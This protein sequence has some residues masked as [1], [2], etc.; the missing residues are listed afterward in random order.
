MD[1][2]NRIGG[3]WS[4]TS[5][6]IEELD[7]STGRP[8][9]AAPASGSAEIDVAVRAAAGAARGWA[10]MPA[11]SRGEILF[12]AAEILGERAAEIAAGIA[13]EIG[14]PIREARGEVARGVAI[15]RYFAGEG[16]RAGGQVIPPDGSGL[17]LTLREPLG[18]VGLITPWNFPLA[19][20]LWKAAPALVV[21]N[22]VVLKP[23]E[24]AAGT[25]TAVVRCL[26]EAGVPA[27]VVGLVC[28]DGRAGSALVAHER[29]GAI[30][31]TGSIPV[32]REIA[33]AAATR[34]VRTQL[35]LGG[36][37]A[38]I[39]LADAD[40]AG[41]A[42]AV[43]NGAF[44]FAGQKCTATGLVL[45]ERAIADDFADRLEAARAATVV[46]AAEDERS[47]CGPLVRADARDRA[48]RSGARGLAGAGYFVE[49]TIRSDVDP[50]SAVCREELFC[51][52]LP[53]VAI[54][55]LDAALEI[56][57]ALP[58][59]LAAAVHTRDGSRILRFLRD[60]RAGLLAV[61]RPTTGLEVQAPF[62]G[63]KA[64]GSGPKE[65]GPDAVEFYSD[66]KTVYWA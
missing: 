56:V 2:L 39:V 29:V 46:A 54:D 40:L 3:E 53:L 21:G 42:A 62:G 10:A 37:N 36:K 33:V 1:A 23:A 32:G 24:E 43:A 35:E 12:R 16:R 61:N 49:P 65:Q 41:A 14:K 60:A 15:L 38:A 8:L 48:V 64:S 19:I 6:T 20:P 58:T 59:G 28:G 45:V 34:G 31:F 9:L 26:V 51:P 50:A 57:E 27:G 63:L 18:V 22:A 25:A 47:V 66:T 13:R 5:E 11:P 55:G 30:S 52:V 7:P 44:A 4:T 17:T